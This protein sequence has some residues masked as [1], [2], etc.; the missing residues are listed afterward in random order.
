MYSSDLVLHFDK[1]G[2]LARDKRKNDSNTGQY[3]LAPCFSNPANLD[4]F[5]GT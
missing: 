2:G 5:F 1:V 3:I 4:D